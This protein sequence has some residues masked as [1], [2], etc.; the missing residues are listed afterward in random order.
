LTLVS[1][2]ILNK[3]ERLLLWLHF[4][5]ILVIY[6]ATGYYSPGFDDEY[7]NLIIVERFGRG[8][9]NYTQSTD[10]HPPLSYL[11]N[12]WLFQLMGSWNWVRM[13]SGILTGAT[14]IATL[15]RMGKRRDVKF[16]LILI[17]LLAFNPAILMWGTSLRWYGYFLPVLIWLLAQA[18][19]IRW[20][21]PKFFLSFLWLGYTGYISFFIFLP[22][23]I[24]YWMKDSRGKK[25]KIKAI[26][27]PGLL[28]ALAYLPQL[29]IFFKV[30][31]P[32]SGGQ[33]FSLPSGLIGILS[34][35]V[36]N[37]GLFPLSTPGIASSIGTMM[38]LLHLSRKLKEEWRSPY[39]IPFVLGEIIMFGTR[40]AGKMRNLSVML[41][42]QAIWFTEKFNATKS[43]WM[44]LAMGLIVYGNLVGTYNVI[45]HEDTTKNSWNLPVD[46][47][48]T[49][50]SDKF[51][52][53]QSSVL[54]YCHDPIITWHLEKMGFLV[55]SIYASNEVVTRDKKINHVLVIW[56]HPGVIPKKT[57]ELFRFEI[58]LIKYSSQ[59]AYILG[60]D[61]Y[62][63]IKRKKDPTY[64]NELVKIS[65]ME[66]PEQIALSSVWSPLFIK[67]FE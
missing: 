44:M 32:R 62:A 63:E 40:I 6:A 18:S 55:R 39:L 34:T 3:Q 9:V 27:L 38:L 24:Y 58:S 12:Y 59:S 29:V 56:T 48:K 57:M 49:F 54:I 33:V 5:L 50:V 7:F 67:R 4:A 65:M 16:S 60:T 21:W 25:E 15:I 22:L 35:H 23:F 17:Y 45:M 26:L 52:M 30:H 42:L 46:Q 43:R 51:K 61:K 64:P 53:E 47:I 41:P 19:N 8:V 36:S 1:S 20:H 11:L 2:Q 14:I 28:A 37:Q 31:Y 10:V 66:H 13:V